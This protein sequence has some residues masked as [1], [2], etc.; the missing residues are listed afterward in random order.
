MLSTSKNVARILGPI[1]AGVL[2]ASIGGGW[3]IAIDSASFIFAAACMGRVVLADPP[4]A[5]ST[6][7]LHGLREGWL[8]FR[9]NS[10]IWSVTAAFAV[11][12]A[13]QVGVWR[14]SARSW[15]PPRSGRRG[16]G[17]C[18]V[19]RAWACCLSAQSC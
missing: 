15:R 4:A 1:V 19:P 6:G 12:N 5:R 17:W 18:S 14:C 2:V 16:G 7:L 8:Y 13:I 9:A 10:W 3:A 11:M